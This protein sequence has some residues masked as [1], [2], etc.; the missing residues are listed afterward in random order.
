MAALLSPC[1]LGMPGVAAEVSHLSVSEGWFMWGLF[2]MCALGSL[3][4]VIGYIVSLMTPMVPDGVHIPDGCA[5]D[6]TGI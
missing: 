6:F 2:H 1:R 3:S 4:V 5:G